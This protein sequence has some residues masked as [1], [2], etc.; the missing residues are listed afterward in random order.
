MQ[1]PSGGKRLAAAHRLLLTISDAQARIP[2]AK[3]ML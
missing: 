1:S 3:K 2:P